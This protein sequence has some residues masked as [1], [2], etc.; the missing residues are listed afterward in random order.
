MKKKGF[1]LIELMAVV[2]ILSL[3]F[4]FIIPEISS[5]IDKGEEQNKVMLE[6]KII[7]AAKEYTLT[8]DTSFLD[9]MSEVGNIKYISRAQLL[10][11]GLIEKEVLDQL[12]EL[13]KF[14][15]V[16][17]EVIEGYNIKYTIVYK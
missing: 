1:T 5:L 11:S 6:E 4:L 12:D 16:K 14:Q 7:S 8:Y 2:V 9:S 17:C 10:N 3:T 13:K 15:K